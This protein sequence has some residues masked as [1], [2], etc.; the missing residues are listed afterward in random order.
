MYEEMK[1]DIW[2]GRIDDYEEG[3]CQRWHQ[4]IHPIDQVDQPGIA[5]LGICSDEGVRRNLG[6][7]GARKGPNSIRRSLAPLPWNLEK[8]LYDAGNLHCDLSNLTELSELQADWIYT[9]LDQGHF[10]LVLGGSHEIAFGN[11]LGLELF[12]ASRVTG[13][14]G[15][16][17]FDAHFDLK[18]DHRPSSGTPFLQI[19]ENCLQA[20]REF[21]YACL[22]ISESSNTQ[23][24]F[25]RADQLGVQ[26]L[27][28]DQ[29]N[30]WQLERAFKLIEDFISPL[31][32]LYLTIDLDCLPAAIAPGVSTPAPRGISLEVL[33]V[34][35]DECKRLAG[36]KLRMADIAEYN[37]DLD[38]DNRTAQLAARLCYRILK[39]R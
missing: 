10:P 14:I 27:K 12:L 18:R 21:Q 22:G 26:Y 19:S 25:Q 38:I 23:A 7:H 29:M 13:N 11:Y 36:N 32:A 6:R 5:I 20:G 24:L 9:L 30:G 4:V 31:A 3:P 33:E 34:L 16:L 8:P 37:P 35:I 15:I 39:N 17:N 28:D 1:N 2:Q